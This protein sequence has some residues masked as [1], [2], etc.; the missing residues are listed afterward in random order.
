M[1]RSCNLFFAHFL[2]R[3]VVPTETDNQVTGNLF[4]SFNVQSGQFFVIIVPDDNNKVSPMGSET[5]C[6]TVALFNS[7]NDERSE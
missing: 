2:E 1:A 3:F 6:F 5:R 4:G 7:L